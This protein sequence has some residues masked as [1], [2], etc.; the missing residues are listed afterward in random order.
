MCRMLGYS[1]EELLATTWMELTHPDDL[2]SSR[3]R[4]VRLRK[5]P[6]G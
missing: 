2:E 1:E 4:L 6:Y 3:R 5:D